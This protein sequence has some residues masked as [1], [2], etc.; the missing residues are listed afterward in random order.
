MVTLAN[1]VKALTSTVG[2]GTLSLG[3]A[4]TG[5]QTFAEGGIQNGD[6]VSYVIEDGT[7]WE[8]GTG[9]FDA[10]S[11]TLTRSVSESSN[12]NSLLSL[13][14]NASVF[15]SVG[16]AELQSLLDI[17]QGLSTT[18]SPVFSGLE[19]SSLVLNGTV[20]SATAEELNILDGLAATT[21]ELNIL[22]GATVTT[23]QLNIL[24][25]ITWTT[26]ASGATTFADAINE[27]VEVVTSSSNS[28]TL[29]CRIS[30]V[31]VHALTE[32]T[33]FSFGDPPTAGTSYGM[34]V[35]ITQDT[36][37]RTVTWPASVVWASGLSPNLSTGSGEVDIFVFFTHDG[38]T[39]WYG[40]TA[41]LD[42]S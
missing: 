3:N 19:I 39:T 11:G 1:R 28:T 37:P 6:T 23:N 24:S 29:D 36:T 40:F 7:N 14:G 10:S 33:T 8:I 21:A 16:K 27:A 34:T 12:S 31:F 2:T 42:F 9:T 26:G 18:D 5:Y 41:G 15:L 35:K 25:E 20:V 38:G 22:D 13:T 30:N 32:N 17:N 4:V